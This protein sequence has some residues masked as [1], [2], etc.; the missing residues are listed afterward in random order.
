[1]EPYA[2]E[3]EI[4]LTAVMKG[5]RVCHRV[6]A[7]HIHGQAFEKADG[8]PV[9]LADLAGQAVITAELRDAFPSDP[10]LG[11][12]DAAMIRKAPEIRQKVFSLAREEQPDLSEERLADLIDYG[13]R[14][15][16]PAGRFWTLDPIDGTKGFLA[17]RQYAV[18]LALMDRGRVAVGI[19]GCPGLEKPPV[20]GDGGRILCAIRGRGVRVMKMDGRDVRWIRRNRSVS[21]TRARLCESVEPSHA[22]HEIHAAIQHRLGIQAPSVRMDSQAKYGALALGAA[23]IYLRIPKKENYAEKIWDHAAG[24]LIIEEAGGTVTDTQ[25]KE[26]DFSQGETLRENKGV[27]ATAGGIHRQVLSAVKEVIRG[28]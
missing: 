17:G 7:R 9:T 20:G 6:Q 18:A 23:D 10:L 2:R 13:R 24:S 1:M 26:L 12:E 22:A 3:T 11:E 14:P 4:G 27:V 8:S 28:C 5:F 19:L 16:N 25:G 15:F 21:I